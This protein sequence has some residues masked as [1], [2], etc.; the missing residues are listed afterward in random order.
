MRT[1]SGD[2][3]VAITLTDSSLRCGEPEE[4]RNC[5]STAAR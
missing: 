5:V 3:S 2:E 1:F 4:V